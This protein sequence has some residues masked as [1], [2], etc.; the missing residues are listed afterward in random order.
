MFGGINFG[1]TWA[2]TR[3]MCLSELKFDYAKRKHVTYHAWITGTGVVQYHWEDDGRLWLG[4]NMASADLVALELE[5]ERHA[6]GSSTWNS[7]TNE[8]GCVLSL[9]DGHYSVDV[10][11]PDVDG[12]SRFVLTDR[13]KKTWYLLQSD[14]YLTQKGVEGLIIKGRSKAE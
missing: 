9:P 11:D 4:P 2:E 1:D 12:R 13:N 7:T 5:R 3:V 8:R 10:Q 6:D 14:G